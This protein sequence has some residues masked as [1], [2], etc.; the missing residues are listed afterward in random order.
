MNKRTITAFTLSVVLVFLTGCA[1]TPSDYRDPGDPFESYNRAMY[2]FNDGLD[3]AIFKPIA[4]GYNAITPEPVNKGITNFFS[5]LADVTSAINNLL[6]LKMHR[7]VNDVG[8][9]LVNTTLGVLGFIDVASNLNLPKTGEDFGQTLGDWGAGPGPYIVLPILGSSSGRDL[10]GAVVDWFTDPV[11]YVDD[12]TT[13]YVLRGLRMVDTRAGLL[14]ASNVLEEA[15][16]DKYIFT[17]DAYL[18]KRRNAVYDGNPPPEDY[19]QEQEPEPEQE[20][21]QE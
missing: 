5:N 19:E 21:K 1:S 17:R 20:Q 10:I 3:R 18:Q 8:R 11:Y 2:R 4:K 7:A 14:K 6:Q 15:A 16:L 12:D 13:R 9:V